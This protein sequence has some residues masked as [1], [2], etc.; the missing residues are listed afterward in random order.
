MKNYKISPNKKFEEYDE[1]LRENKYFLMKYFSTVESS[2]KEYKFIPKECLDDKYFVFSCLEKNPDI[3][4]L[5]D[6]VQ[7][8][9]F[10]E[11]LKGM[12]KNNYLK[13]ASKDNFE[14]KSFCLKAVADSPFNYA[15]LPTELRSDKFLIKKVFKDL[16]RADS[17]SSSIPSK[18][19]KDREFMFEL[20]KENIEVFYGVKRHF[21]KDREIMKHLTIIKSAIFQEA[22]EALKSDK[23]WVNEILE[24]KRKLEK[25]YSF[26][27]LRNFNISEII[28]ELPKSF[29]EDKS[30]II[31]NLAEI[32]DQY[33]DFKKEIRNC[34]VLIKTIYSNHSVEILPKKLDRIMERYFIKKIPIEELKIKLLD[35]GKNNHFYKDEEEKIRDFKD[36]I[37]VVDYFFL[38]KELTQKNNISDTKKLKI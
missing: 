25:E 31:N 21:K 19:I 3:Y 2:T 6:N 37:T 30:F 13:Y 23:S 4:L 12:Y 15:Y 24:Q 28:S 5:A 18:V 16:Y 33:K 26:N 14:D 9:E 1:E 29:Y 7:S 10:F 34:D 8:E 20:M 35:F 27:N 11:H 17:I 32:V 22:D 38:G 36:F